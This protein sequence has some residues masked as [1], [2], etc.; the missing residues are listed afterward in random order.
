MS[1]TE[2]QNFDFRRVICDDHVDGWAEI[3]RCRRHRSSSNYRLRRDRACQR[4]NKFT[5][6]RGDQTLSNDFGTNYKATKCPDDSYFASCVTGFYKFTP[7]G[8]ENWFYVGKS[9]LRAQGAD[10]LFAVAEGAVRAS[11]PAGYSSHGIQMT[12]ASASAPS[13]PHETWK[14]AGSADVE[15]Q[16]MTIQDKLY[17]SLSLTIQ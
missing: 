16:I 17:Y 5:A 6:L 15:L 7:T 3:C 1:Q 9:T 11:L 13:L 14:Q 2:S 10:V 4:S 8:S 12:T